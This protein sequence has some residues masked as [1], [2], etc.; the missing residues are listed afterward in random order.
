MRQHVYQLGV[1]KVDKVAKH[2]RIERD[3]IYSDEELTIADI[4][5]ISKE[6]E[7]DIQLIYLGVLISPKKEKKIEL[8][9]YTKEEIE[10]QLTLWQ[11]E[12]ELEKEY[13]DYVQKEKEYEQSI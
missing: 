3:L 12:K 10:A 13:D 11:H 9:Y 5:K 1:R 7:C 8:D 2:Y 4:T 6:N